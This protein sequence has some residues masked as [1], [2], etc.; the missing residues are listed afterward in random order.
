M[1]VCGKFGCHDHFD[2]NAKIK[3]LEA[4]REALLKARNA[5]CM[6]KGS[7]NSCYEK[8]MKKLLFEALN[9]YDAAYGEKK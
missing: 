4:E 3:S 1:S 7:I 8:D 6:W 5:A 2:A 9:A